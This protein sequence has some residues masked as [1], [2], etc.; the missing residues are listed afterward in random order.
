MQKQWLLFEYDK[1]NVQVKLHLNDELN[2]LGVDTE[3]SIEGSCLVEV[4]ELNRAD[5]LALRKQYRQKGISIV[6]L[7]YHPSASSKK[8]EIVPTLDVQ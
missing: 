8:N 5:E 6:S 3:I 1:Y 4:E 2:K 7:K